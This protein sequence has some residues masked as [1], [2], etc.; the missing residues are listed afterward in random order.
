MR[1]LKIDTFL[2]EF[3]QK[4]PIKVID[5]EL[6]PILEI[7]KVVI[8]E[9]RY[10]RDS[11]LVF[12]NIKNFRSFIAISNILNTRSKL[13]NLLSVNND[14]ELY[15]K[16]LNS[17]ESLTE[18]LEGILEVSS[19]DFKLVEDFDL[20]MLP[21]AKF[22]DK[23]PCQYLTSGV[24]VGIDLTSNFINMSIHRLTPIDRDK[25][26]IRLVP[27]HLYTIWRRNAEKG[28]DTPVAIVWT[29]NPVFLLAASCSPPFGVSE[30]SLVGKFV[31]IPV[32]VY[33]ENGLIPIPVDAE[34]V[35]IGKLVRDCL[36]SEGPYADILRLYD[37]VRLQPVIKI[38]K[39]YIQNWKDRTVVHYLV[40][41]LNEHRVLMSIEKEAKIWKFVSNVVP[42]VKAIRLTPGGGS[43]L[44][45]VI[46]IRKNT[47]G[48]AKNAILAAFAAHP[49]L[50]HVV[51]VDEDVDVDNP[52]DVEWAI[53]TRF[54]A[55]RDL[56]IIQNVRGSTLDPS[57]IDQETGLTVKVGID[58]TRPCKDSTKFEK[59]TNSTCVEYNFRIIKELSSLEQL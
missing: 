15:K 7:P 51:V 39:L 46:S 24:V 38:E 44:H 21:F 11:I 2:I 12:N 5:N 57:C 30:L 54:R 32:K 3:S 53:A 1:D 31:N 13:Y 8:E 55:D 18:K 28:R 41:G 26:A 20:R 52:E 42:H 47:D 43:W 14:D 6:S 17:I 23:E 16:I 34:I 59:V 33:F 22:Y 56:I 45:A 50:K 25:L 10:D 29:I 27:R 58:A 49:S 4:F 19:H 9:E 40:P 48:D 37:D 35:M 36:H